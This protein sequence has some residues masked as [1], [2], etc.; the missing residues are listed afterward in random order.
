MKRMLCTFISTVLLMFPFV[1]ASNSAELATPEEVIQKTQEAA[2]F[3]AEEIAKGPEAEKAA[4][5]YMNKQEN[6]RFVWKDTYVWVLCCECEPKTNAAHPINQ[7]IVGPDLSGMKDK[8]G[9]LFFL[10][11]C[12]TSRNPKG[13]WVEYWWPK[14]GETKASRKI[15]YVVKV[16]GTKYQVGAGTYDEKLDAQALGKLIR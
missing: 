10:Q 4:L 9:N 1:T 14:V 6:N 3:L 12:E 7:K 16:P 8:Q 13:G 5:A 15:T 2:K 11:F